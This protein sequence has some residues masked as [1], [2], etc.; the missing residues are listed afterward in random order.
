MRSNDFPA[1]AGPVTDTVSFVDIALTKPLLVTMLLFHCI[2]MTH[3]GICCLCKINLSC[4]LHR[5][6]SRKKSF[7]MY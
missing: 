1:A 6:A 3:E 5:V 2:H 7:E 4:L